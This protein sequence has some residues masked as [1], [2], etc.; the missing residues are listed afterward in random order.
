[1]AVGRSQP[2]LA[3]SAVGNE[4]GMATDLVC[5]DWRSAD[6]AECDDYGERHTSNIVEKRELVIASSGGYP[7]DIN[8]IQAHKALEAA[9]HACVDGG[10]IV[11]LAECRDGLG[12]ADFL[13][14]FEA[15]NS[16]TLAEVL[17][18]KYKVNGQTA[19]SLLKKAE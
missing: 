2:S 16:G 6:R 17:C 9:S 8:M 14:W 5:G 1:E 18:E 19:W 7:H 10:T 3:V 12:R 11:F 4:T 15:K 13:K